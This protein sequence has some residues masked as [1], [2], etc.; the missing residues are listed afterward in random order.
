MKEVTDV[1]F[2]EVYSCYYHAV[3]EIL[4][5]ALEAPV[6]GKD[7]SQIVR[8]KAFEESIAAIPDALK[9]QRWPLLDDTGATPLRHVPTLPLTTLQKRWLKALLADPRIVL[10][11][12]PA[13]G[14]ED[15][16]PLY[17]PDMLV[18]FD[19]YADGD[20][21]DDPVYQ[22]HFRTVLTALRK[23][24]CIRVRFKGH[25]GNRQSWFCVPYRLEYSQKDD[26][27]RLI[28]SLKGHQANVNIARIRSVELLRPYTRAE[29][30]PPNRRTETLVLD[31]IDQ[32]N[33]LER[34]M[35]HFS[36][37]EKETQKLD[38]KH[39]RMTLH[40]DQEDE[41]ELV[42]RVLSFGP[43]VQVVS[44][45]PFV[46]LIRERLDRQMSCGFLS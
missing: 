23:K 38:D 3:A 16:E 7:I 32:R 34:V 10:F 31:I 43:M 15:I 14:L 13:E 36:N 21:Y 8:E 22:E 44:S 27:F 30:R 46:A 19:Q 24:H 35:L 4:A 42:I 5:Q 33:A 18:Y 45:D 29:Y 37:L 1:V 28:T 11:D 41:T 25:R 26:K 12:P 9:A 39:Y 6:T 20:P 40:Y 17:T 2:H